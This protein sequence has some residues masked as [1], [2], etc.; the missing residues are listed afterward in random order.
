MLEA[1]EREDSVLDQVGSSGGGEKWSHSGCDLKDQLSGFA[2][3][4][5]G[6][7]ERREG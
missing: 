7:W 6:G 5:N 3:P 4:W 2:G 1:V